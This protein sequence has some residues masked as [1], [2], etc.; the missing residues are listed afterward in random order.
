MAEEERESGIRLTSAE[1]DRIRGC[2]P[3]G[4]ESLGR[5]RPILGKTLMNLYEFRELNPHHPAA[6]G[7]APAR[8]SATLRPDAG[9]PNCFLGRGERKA[10]IPVRELEELAVLDCGSWIEFLHLR[11]DPDRKATGIKTGNRSDSGATSQESFPGGCNGVA[12]RS[13]DSEP[14]DRYAASSS[15]HDVSNRLTSTRA[16]D[17]R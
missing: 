1:G 4:T 7:A 8:C 3:R 12:E 16:V 14:G 15:C 9:V 17:T 11:S 13:H 10:V 5:E 6:D 2:H